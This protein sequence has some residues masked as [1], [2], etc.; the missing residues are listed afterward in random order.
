MFRV[1]GYDPYRTTDADDVVLA[2]QHKFKGE[3]FEDFPGKQSGGIFVI[4]LETAFGW[5]F[6]SPEYGNGIDK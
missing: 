1:R 3:L 2:Q 4:L 5:R 6:G